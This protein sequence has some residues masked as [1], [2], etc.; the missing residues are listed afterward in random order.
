MYPERQVADINVIMDA[1]QIHTDSRYLVTSL[2]SVLMF[3]GES[4]QRN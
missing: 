4:K 2:K 3:D 1:K